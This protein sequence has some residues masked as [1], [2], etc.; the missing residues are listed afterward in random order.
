MSSILSQ[1]EDQRMY[2]RM[3]PYC[4]QGKKVQ[5]GPGWSGRVTHHQSEISPANRMTHQCFT[6]LSLTNLFVKDTFF[7][8]CTLKYIL[9]SLYFKFIFWKSTLWTEI[10]FLFWMRVDNLDFALRVENGRKLTE[11]ASVSNAMQSF[12]LY[13]MKKTTKH[14]LL[15]FLKYKK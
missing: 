1:L 4:L 8:K 11:F 13:F 9:K 3:D 6:E 2:S 7:I 14:I 5:K 15:W 12:S 10:D